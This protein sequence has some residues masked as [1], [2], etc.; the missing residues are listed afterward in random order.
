VQK[1]I[2]RYCTAL[3]LFAATCMPLLVIGQFCGGTTG[4][5][6][7]YN[8]FGTGDLPQ[9]AV[10]GMI[11]EY[12]F[13]YYNRC[14]GPKGYSVLNFTYDCFGY[15][16]H[17]VE[18][19]NDHTLN[20]VHGCFMLVNCGEIPGLF[21]LDTL[22]NLTGGKNYELSFWHANLMKP[23]FCFG[24]PVP[25]NLT[26][27][28]ESL[29]GAILGSFNTGILPNTNTLT[30]KQIALTFSVPANQ[31]DVIIK[32]IDNLGGACGNDFVIDDWV[33]RE[34]GQANIRAG[35]NFGSFQGDT[36]RLC[37][38]GSANISVSEKS[39]P[40]FGS[41]LYQWQESYDLGVTWTDI[42]GAITPN[43]SLSYNAPDTILLRLKVAES[44]CVAGN[45][46]NCYVF[47]NV[48]VLQLSAGGNYA[49]TSNSPVCKGNNIFL[50]AIDGA[51]EYTWT[52]P[53]NFRATGA[54]I[55]IPNAA[56]S[57]S[58]KY[59]VAIRN[60]NQCI[61]YDSTIVSVAGS[62]VSDAGPDKTIAAGASVQLDGSS[63]IANAIYDWNPK[64]FLD[65]PAIPNPTVNP[66]VEMPYKLTV[67]A[68]G[69]CGSATDEVTVKVLGE[70]AIPNAFTPN[71]DGNNDT[72]R[73]R[74][75]SAYTK[76]F[77]AI[78]NRYGQLVFSEQGYDKPWDGLYRNQPLPSG[79]YFY[80]IR[81]GDEKSQ[82]FKGAVT[83]IR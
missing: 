48:I 76:S 24:S 8:T 42:A 10:K 28:A 64:I 74:G 77:I 19:N 58:G 66:P 38:N 54:S 18:V 29:N 26:L 60:A 13:E 30:W 35:F 36:A 12:F 20:D 49:V 21:Y 2:V 40:L 31:K 5:T 32:I 61:Q 59:Y 73:I 1:K 62:P 56:A 57:S 53:N 34:C 37:A 7:I 3:L 50:T 17:N 27:V 75:L 15:S 78:Y 45:K 47:S 65:N 81:L 55:T 33:V 9:P 83:L 79:T 51:V 46:P 71:G 23:P 67:T 11:P 43:F 80:V 72:W 22:K 82:Q 39:L 70:I 63:N 16:W 68:P 14:P 25:N 4:D 41:P 44:S 69:G 6:I 52:G